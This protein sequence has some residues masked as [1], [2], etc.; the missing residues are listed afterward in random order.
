M[1][2]SYSREINYLKISLTEKCN[3]RCVYCKDEDNKNEENVIEDTIS[4]EDFKFLIKN[5]AQLGINK[6]KFVGGEPLLY[7]YLKELIHFANMNVI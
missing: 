5:F 4:V 7:P 3:L 6:I 2:D 1:R